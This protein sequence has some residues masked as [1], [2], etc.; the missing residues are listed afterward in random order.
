M[1]LLIKQRVFSWSDSYDIY[2]EAGNTKYFVKAEI[3]SFGHQLHVYDAYQNDIGFIRQKLF[4]FM[5]TFEI[6]MNGILKGQ[7]KK[8]FSFLRPRYNVDFNGWYVEGDF[9]G[10]EYDVRKGGN[11]IAHISKELFRWGDTYVINVKE[12]ADEL[13]AMMLVIAIDAA[14]CSS[15]NVNH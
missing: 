3:F 2:D 11:I 12:A 13:M 6:E 8:E 7:V 4:S 15:N 14:N 5:P 1:K 10:W 9:L